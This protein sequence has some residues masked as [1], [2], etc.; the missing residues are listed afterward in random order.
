MTGG[1]AKEIAIRTV[2]REEVVGE[3]AK[4]DQRGEMKTKKLKN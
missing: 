1:P 4:K 2:V 3:E